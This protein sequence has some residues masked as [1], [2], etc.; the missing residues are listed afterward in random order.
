MRSHRPRA[1]RR[2][3]RTAFAAGTSAS[4]SLLLSSELAGFA[5][6]TA[7]A[8]FAAFAGAALAALAGGASSSLS[9]EELSAGFAALAAAGVT[10]FAAAG[11]LAGT[12]AACEARMRAA[13][14][15]RNTPCTRG[16]RST[17]LRGLR[18]GRRRSVTGV[19]ARVR[20]RRGRRC[21]LLRRRRGGLGRGRGR[22][23]RAGLGRR[24]GCRGRRLRRRLR[25]LRGG[26]RGGAVGA[27]VV[28]AGGLLRNGSLGYARRARRGVMGNAHA[29]RDEWSGAPC[30]ATT[31]TGAAASLLS[32]SDEEAST[33]GTAARPACEH[34]RRIAAR[35]QRGPRTLLASLGGHRS[36]CETLVVARARGGAQ[37]SHGEE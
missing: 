7:F 19:A 13:H 26:G 17:R 4:E 5:T 27:A 10:G 37:E 29:R 9:S 1:T 15:Q 23:L 12:A 6:A 21:G 28:A 14:A 32:L 34:C 8:G 22:A 25:G 30:F 3:G 36:R 31:V 11:D 35:S 16:R 33:T 24:R 2:C 18:R 20:R